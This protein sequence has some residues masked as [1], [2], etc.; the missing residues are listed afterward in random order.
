MKQRPRDIA[1][2][3]LVLL[4]EIGRTDPPVIGTEDDLEGGDN[5]D[6]PERAQW[7]RRY[8][9]GSGDHRID[10]ERRDDH[11]DQQD[12]LDGR[13]DDLEPATLL[14]TQPVDHRHGEENRRSDDRLV[15][16][17]G[18][19]NRPE[20]VCAGQR[21]RRASSNICGPVR[22]TGEHPQAI[23]IG[24]AHR[25]INPARLGQGRSQ[26]GR[27][28]ARKQHIYPAQHPQQHG[29]LGNRHLIRDDTRRAHDAGPDDR[30]GRNGDGEGQAETLLQ[31]ACGLG[32]NT[33]GNVPEAK[34]SWHG[35]ANGRSF[36][37]IMQD[38]LLA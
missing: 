15:C 17:D 31:V 38:L 19:E 26:F 4:R 23:P 28:I 10:N 8:R 1:R 33:H 29:Y 16:S 5:G 36:A 18:L 7:D 30:P 35:P 12:D 14:H 37:C 22:P 20:K 32:I 2:R 9:I 21:Q 11:A 24:F 13:T 25:D 27:D 34:A 3:I 6:D